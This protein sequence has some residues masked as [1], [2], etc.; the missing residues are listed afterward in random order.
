MA[1]GIVDYRKLASRELEDAIL[2][3]AS[4]STR[5]RAFRRRRE[6]LTEEIRRRCTSSDATAEDQFLLGR[7]IW[8]LYSTLSPSLSLEALRALDESRRHPD[9]SQ[10][11]SLFSLYLFE[12]CKEYRAALVEADGL[13]RD[14]FV[15]HDL[16]WRWLTALECRFSALVALGQSS[17]MASTHREILS[18]LAR[19]DEIGAAP[20][21]VFATALRRAVRNG[22]MPTELDGEDVLAAL[23]ALLDGTGMAWVLDDGRSGS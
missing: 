10:M 20:P 11:S 4:E 1:S 3:L 16:E 7:S 8:S 18:W 14:W 13:D 12:R 17:E 5:A 19:Q 15:S 22:T 23:K 9:L 6:A 2:D 21:K